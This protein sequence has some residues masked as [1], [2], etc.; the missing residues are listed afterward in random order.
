VV[1]G[2][3]AR[4]VRRWVEGEGWVAEKDAVAP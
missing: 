3:P 2:V 1:A 4:V